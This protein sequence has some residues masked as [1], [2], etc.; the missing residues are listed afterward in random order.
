MIPGEEPE[1]VIEEF[2]R[3]VG[4]VEDDNSDVESEVKVMNAVGP[5]ET[6]E[7]SPLVVAAV[8]AAGKVLG[9]PVKPRGFVARCDGRF[10]SEKGVSTIILGAGSLDQAHKVDEYV[11]IDQI[12]DAVKIYLRL[13]VRLLC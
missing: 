3:L 6:D 13:A 5:M 2:H 4:R 11:D 12:V 9:K 7:S 1:E 10:L 8:E